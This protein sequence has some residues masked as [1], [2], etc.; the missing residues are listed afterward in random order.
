MKH[1]EERLRQVKSE[2]VTRL[3]C[4]ICKRVAQDHLHRHAPNWSTLESDANETTVTMR[5]GS[6]WPGG[7]SG[8]KVE[9][10]ICPD[11][12][13]D[14]LIP[15]VKEQGGEPTVTEWDY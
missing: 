15:W 14:K 13:R 9:I 6:T 5:T 8:E 4:D 11:C 12:F 3:Q 7:G 10:D 1:I 2:V